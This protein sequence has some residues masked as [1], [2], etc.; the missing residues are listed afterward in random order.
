M[1]DIEKQVAGHYGVTDLYERIIAAFAGAGQDVDALTADDLKPVDEFH[2]GG[3]AATRDL[4]DPLGLTASTR[5]LDIGCGLGGSARFMTQRFGAQVTGLDLTPEF[6]RTARLLSD[7]VGL[8]IA[9]VVGSALDLPFEAATFDV[10]TLLHV[11]MNLPDK[12]RLFA[13][14]ARVLVPGGRFVVYDVMR[15]GDHPAFPLPWAERAESSFLETPDAYLAAAEASGL[16]LRHRAD[17]GAVA[18]AF[19]CTDASAYGVG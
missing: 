13:E 4:L 9:F 11:G 15:F 18:R 1:S 17:R 6:V 2:I 3:V 12:P 8:D 16:A 19:F 7:K 10:V 5:L 14:A